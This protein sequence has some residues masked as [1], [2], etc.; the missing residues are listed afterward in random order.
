MLC[1]GMHIPWLCLGK[2][3]LRQVMLLHQSQLWLSMLTR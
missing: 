1:V 3:V 2:Q